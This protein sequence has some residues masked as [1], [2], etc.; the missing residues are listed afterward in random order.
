[1]S[2]LSSKVTKLLFIL[3]ASMV[4]ATIVS[5]FYTFYFEQNYDFIVEVPCNSVEE[6]CYVRHCGEGS[7]CP[8]N[9]LEQYRMLNLNAADFNTC[10]TNSCDLACAS[11]VISCIEILCGD[12]ADDTCTIIPTE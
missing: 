5:N 7:E 9:G 1:M 4:L 8:P 6:V 2:N 11:N 3:I 12:S 10:K